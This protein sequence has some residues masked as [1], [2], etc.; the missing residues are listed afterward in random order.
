MLV[1][2]QISLQQNK[3]ILWNGIEPETTWDQQTIAKRQ[4]TED[5]FTDSP[6]GRR[7]NIITAY[8]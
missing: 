2:I 5:T 7:I 8:D 1:Q 4:K 6:G 3:I